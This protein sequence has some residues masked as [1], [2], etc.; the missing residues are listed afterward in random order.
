MAMLSCIDDKT[1][2]M[3]AL[4]AISRIWTRAAIQLPLGSNRCRANMQEGFMKVSRGTIMA[5]IIFAASAAAQNSNAETVYIPYS[6]ALQGNQGEGDPALNCRP[7]LVTPGGDYRFSNI[8]DFD[9]R[10]DFP[11]TV[12]VGHTIQQISVIYGTN[13]FWY[14][15]GAIAA[16]LVVTSLQP[17]A[18]STTTKFDWN[19]V[20]TLPLEVHP[21]MATFGKVYID[22]FPV[23]ANTSYQVEVTLSSGAQ[24][25]AIAVTYN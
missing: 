21:L 4:A 23:A 9:C 2:G 8:T 20:S 1:F 11:L 19:Y 25:S 6:A 15:S 22:Q 24:V 3:S 5:A 10:L 7:N 13:T 16:K 17:P 12:P 18:Q 14:A